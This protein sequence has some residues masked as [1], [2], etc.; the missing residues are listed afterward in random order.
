MGDEAVGEV[1]GDEAAFAAGFVRTRSGQ[2]IHVGVE[3][4]AEIA[5]E[6]NRE[7]APPSPAPARLWIGGAILVSS[8]IV[9]GWYIAQGRADEHASID[10]GL[11]DF[12][13]I[14]KERRGHGITR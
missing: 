7:S 10:S 2:L 5:A 13:Y 11:G 8:L 14:I 3:R 9:V 1:D 4:A 12:G 6:N